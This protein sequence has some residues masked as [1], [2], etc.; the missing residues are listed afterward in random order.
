MKSVYPQLC[1]RYEVRNPVFHLHD[2]R[3]SFAEQSIRYCLVKQLNAENGSTITTGMVHTSS[4][5]SYKY[6]IKNEVI[7]NYSVFCNIAKCHVCR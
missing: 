3:H 7:T 6:R 4:F 5:P 2:I 1:S